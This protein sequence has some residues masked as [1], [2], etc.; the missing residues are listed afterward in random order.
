MKLI[1]F[2]LVLD[3]IIVAESFVGRLACK[4]PGC[5]TRASVVQ[6]GS[7][8]PGGR[9]KWPWFGDTFQ[10][11]NAKTM[12]S[13]QVKTR[14]KYGPIWR[15]SIFFKDTVFVTGT[16]NL[17][18]AFIEEA[19]KST[20]AFFPPHH[21]KLFGENSLL[22]QSG[23]YHGKLR[24]VISSSLSPSA[25]AQLEGLIQQN[26][27]A[28]IT[29]CKQQSPGESFKFADKCRSFF[30]KLAVAVLLGDDVSDKDL[31]YL[32]ADISTWSKGLLSA[33]IT[34]IPWSTASRAMRA[35]KRVARRITSSIETYR[36][37]RPK[38]SSSSSSAAAPARNNLLFRLVTT[39]DDVDNDF[40]SIEAI[41]DNIFTLIFAGSDTTTSAMTSI[42]K[43]LSLDNDLQE[44]LRKAVREST[45]HPLKES[46]PASLRIDGLIQEVFA[47]YPPAPFSMRQVGDEAITLPNGY[48]VPP[49]WL[50]AFGYAG[51]LLSEEGAG[52]GAGVSGSSVPQVQPP[53]AS[54]S[55]KSLAFGGG[56]RMCP[57]RYL[58]IRELKALV[59]ELLGTNGFLW[60][61]DGDQDLEATYTPGFFPVDGLRVRVRGGGV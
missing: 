44:S 10:L 57:G 8:A 45:T 20:S 29:E 60:T 48:H 59:F 14:E 54:S 22:V 49:N 50:L 30:I 11:I 47:K 55:D 34:F 13:Y 46:D 38:S 16:E 37:Q 39:I 1:V 9:G 52:S 2:A 5:T 58:A 7:M 31:D 24:R 40:L 53:A 17:K 33:P 36:Q 4:A 42:V 51:T 6:G 21:K 56:P 18:S 27:C 25:V 43:T 35:R 28:F 61:L 26:V 41:V 23:A 15:T 3:L 12:A 19:K 32:A